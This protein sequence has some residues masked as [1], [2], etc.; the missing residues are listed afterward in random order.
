MRKMNMQKIGGVEADSGFSSMRGSTVGNP[1]TLTR[2]KTS[3]RLPASS[4]K[5]S[6]KGVE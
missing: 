1:G 6:L 4:A 3:G 5:F 2:N